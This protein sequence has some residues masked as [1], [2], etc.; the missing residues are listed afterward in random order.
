MWVRG[1]G[2]EDGICRPDTHPSPRLLEVH[3]D[4][5]NGQTPVRPLAGAGKLP[6]M[7]VTVVAEGKRGRAQGVFGLAM[8]RYLLPQLVEKPLHPGPFEAE[9]SASPFCLSL[10]WW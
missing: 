9:L 2:E 6:L 3:S 5:R 7:K 4:A 1:A 10:A 8:V